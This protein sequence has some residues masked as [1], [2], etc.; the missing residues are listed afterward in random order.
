MHQEEGDKKVEEQVEEQEEEQSPE[1]PLLKLHS[2]QE[3]PK[4]EERTRAQS[5]RLEWFE[6]VG[7]AEVGLWGRRGP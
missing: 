4:R 7:R 5:K 6:E 1:E 3:E 2:P